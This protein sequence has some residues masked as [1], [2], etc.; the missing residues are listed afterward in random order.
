MR[1]GRWFATLIRDEEGL[2]T[3]EYAVLLSGLIV[4]AGAIW[5]VLTNALTTSAE[6]AAQSVTPN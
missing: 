2:V 3:V 1:I 6:Q 5:Q 4:G